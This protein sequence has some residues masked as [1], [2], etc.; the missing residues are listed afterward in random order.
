MKHSQSTQM[1]YFLDREI[2][3]LF[4]HVKKVNDLLAQRDLVWMKF[5]YHTGVR[6]GYFAA[7]S[8][9]D[10]K[11]IIRTG[12]LDLPAVKGGKKGR[13]R[14]AK[15]AIQDMRALLR[16]RK[17]MGYPDL[18]EAPLVY[19][20]NH[21][22]MAVRSYQASVA[23]W[24]TDAGLDLKASPH[25]F[26]HTFARNFLARTTA[27]IDRALVLLQHQLNHKSINSTMQYLR[28]GRDEIEQAMDDLDFPA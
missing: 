19:S 1:K 13:V 10:G 5:L 25:W 27:P 20:R 12:R 7:L 4:K 14:V 26:R 6:I 23:Y 18:P 15:A 8:V 17:K 3:Q 9:L 24:V 11:E 16:I 21:D 28:P 2:K 22:R